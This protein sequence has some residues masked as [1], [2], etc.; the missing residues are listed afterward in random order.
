M[1]S[2]RD[3]DAMRAC[4]AG[5]LFLFHVSVVTAEEAVVDVDA[6]S[7]LSKA[8]RIAATVELRAG[9][10]AVRQSARP[11]EGKEFAFSDF[12]ERMTKVEMLLAQLEARQMTNSDISEVLELLNVEFSTLYAL[13]PQIDAPISRGLMEGV[14]AVIEM[15]P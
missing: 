3:M 6:S 4:L 7:P 14:K 8:S 1:C 13:L 10:E 11:R 9:L 2:N 5:L 12:E 15:E